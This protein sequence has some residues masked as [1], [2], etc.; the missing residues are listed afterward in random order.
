MFMGLGLNAALD[1]NFK[2][3]ELTEIT[4]I[5]LVP[6]D[7]DEKTLK[8]YKEHFSLWIIACGL[9]ELMETFATFL[10]E[11]HSAS[12]LIAESVGRT[13]TT[14]RVA[15]DKK[16][17]QKGIKEKLDLLKQGFDMESNYTE[18]LK[19]IHQARNCLTHRQGIVGPE[20]CFGGQN[21]IVKWFGLDIYTETPSGDIIPLQPL[22]PG[23]IMLP[24][25]GQVKMR[26]TER[27][28]TFPLKS[29]VTFSPRDLAE[30]CHL[31]L[32]STDEIISSAQAYAI[33]EGIPM[34]TNSG[35]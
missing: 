11:V 9:R 19:T 35:A 14:D 31:V 13:S 32:L 1:P 16:Y 26:F 18:A 22:P 34:S 15:R 25:G 10:D 8:H 29:P 23:G 21:L 5:Q 28:R 2:A 6:P 7:A 3:Y 27:L 33:K 12:L 30:I 17:R 20:D 24:E 4:S